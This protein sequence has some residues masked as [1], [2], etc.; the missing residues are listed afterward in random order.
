MFFVSV[1]YILL[2]EAYLLM[3]IIRHLSFREIYFLYHRFLQVL[4][5][6]VLFGYPSKCYFEHCIKKTGFSD[7]CKISSGFFLFYLPEPRVQGSFF[8]TLFVWR[9]SF[10]LSVRLQTFSFLTSSPEQSVILTKFGNLSLKS[11]KVCSNDG[12]ILKGDP[13]IKL[14]KK[15]INHQ[16]R[17]ICLAV[18]FIYFYFVIWIFS[19]FFIES[20]FLKGDWLSLKFATTIQPS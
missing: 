14:K 16:I 9:P 17:L 19:H 4:A 1:A 12:P 18:N 2:S 11:F 8:W 15:Q 10:Y 7:I 6:R 3:A 13:L 5:R 20:S